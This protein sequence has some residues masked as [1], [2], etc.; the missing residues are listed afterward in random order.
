MELWIIA[1]V[2]KMVIESGSPSQVTY[3]MMPS[4][5]YASMCLITQGLGTM[6]VVLRVLVGMTCMVRLNF[7]KRASLFSFS[8]IL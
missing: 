1:N 3:Q 7:L 8:D 4:L 2:S 6:T 5:Y